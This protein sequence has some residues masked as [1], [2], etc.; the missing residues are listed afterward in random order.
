MVPG[1]EERPGI[2]L[3]GATGFLGGELLARLLMRDE[4]PIYVLVRAGDQTEAKARLDATLTALLGSSRPWTDRAFAVHGDITR[5]SLG[6]DR[7]GHRWLAERAEWIIHAAAS[8]SFT[9]GLD[10]S[11]EINV[12]GTRRMLDLAAMARDLG[13][14]SCFTH[15]STAYVA[16][17]H[18]GTFRERDLDIG[19]EHRNPYERSKLEAEAEVRERSR[20][21]PVQV[22]RPSI[23]VGDSRTGWTPAFNVL[24]WPLRAFARGSYPVLPASPDSPV[25][26]VPVDYVA[27]A[28]L[29][30]GERPGTTFHLTAGD[31]TAS[32]GD[33]VDLACD[34]LERPA[35]RLLSPSIY[36]RVMH[37]VLVR[38]GPEKRRRALRRSEPFFPYFAMGTR[39]DD[40]HARA[41]L[42]PKGIEPPALA[43]YFDRLMGYALRAEWGR[44][45]VPRHRLLAPGLRPR[46]REGHPGEPPRALGRRRPMARGRASHG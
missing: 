27:D 46:S 14:L 42:G 4:R 7:D 18:E 34:H 6:L 8:V 5:E 3:T 10:E 29:E 2:V 11:R 39:Y 33:L 37:P 13:G 36:R 25:D 12:Q 35:P 41:A 23:V 21:L 30:L 24:Y 44:S 9:L 43:S 28:L 16:G 45:P 20:A 15:V 31:R 19:Q 17:T 32:L 26:V 40:S 22:F 1:N 38:T